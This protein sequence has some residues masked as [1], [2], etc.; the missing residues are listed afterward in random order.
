MRQVILGRTA[1]AIYDWETGQR[2][3]GSMQIA[4]MA[5]AYRVPVK[6]LI[7]AELVTDDCAGLPS[8]D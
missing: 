7:G 8:R 6:E 3:P 5:H 4:K 2:A 1:R